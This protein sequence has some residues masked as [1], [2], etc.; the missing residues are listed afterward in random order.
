ML[1]PHQH[2][3]SPSPHGHHLGNSSP[4]TFNT[5][6]TN[7]H[8]HLPYSHGGQDGSN[9]QS[10][11]NNGP[12][13]AHRPPPPS[14]ST[15]SGLSGSQSQWNGINGQ[16]WPHHTKSHGMSSSTSFPGNG[17]SYS[18]HS[19]GANLQ[20]PSF[21]RIPQTS[22]S[23]PQM[24]VSSSSG[25]G[26]GG[27]RSSQPSPVQSI[28]PPP[29]PRSKSAHHHLSNSPMCHDFSSSHPPPLVKHSP[30]FHPSSSTSS[31]DHNQNSKPP[32]L[33]KH[34]LPPKHSPQG[35]SQQQIP[36]QHR[37]THEQVSQL[38]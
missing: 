34:A 32:Q 13:P 21:G 24:S 15:P 8:E 29:V 38:A 18:G 12:T 7:G 27:T 11:P 28:G 26:S 17:N 37:L 31:M 1:P 25:S 3:V 6:G 10:Y 9:F 16:Q 36:E 22:P 4:L 30:N 35:Q 20:H 5:S 2:L 19:H 14:P 23:T 33:P